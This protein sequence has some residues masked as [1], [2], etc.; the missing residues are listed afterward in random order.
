M[1]DPGG[2]GNPLQGLLGDLL[3]L[4]GGS[5]SGAA[6]WLE[7]A[8]TLA[9]GVA[10]DGQPEPNPDPLQRIHLEELAR[11][12]ELHVAEATGLA[13]GSGGS[14]PALVPV[15][16]G[17]WALATLDSWAPLMA[18]MIKAQSGSA[19][20][21]GPGAGGLPG[22]PDDPDG[23]EL[24]GLGELMSRF[25]T[26]MGP[27]LLG[28]QFGSAA[29]HLAQRALGRYALPLPWLGGGDLGLVPQNIAAFAEDW[30]LPL[31]QAQLWVCIH[32]LAAHAVLSQPEVA[33]HIG[34]L[35]DAAV[36]TA[37][38]ST[39]SLTERMG[40]Q[41]GD[42]DALQNLLSDPEALLSD[43]LSPTERYSSE[44]LVAVTTAVGAYVD[45]VT[46]RVAGSLLG[47]PGA[48]GEAW[49][50]Y[51]TADAAG[52]QAA[53]TLFGLDLGRAQVDRGAAFVRGVVER[54]GEA[55][56]ARLWESARNLPT[57]A[58]LDAPGLW[59]ERIDLPP[60]GDGLR[61]E[62]AGGGEPDGPAPDGEPPAG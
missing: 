22:D 18:R 32:E 62:G 8:R 16:R 2:S 33:A 39:Q 54:A 26:T 24:A 61:P 5:P 13:A 52:E 48:L 47:S 3:K 31:D 44:R 40:G 15:G 38:T 49:Y 29:G 36:G 28:M 46:S 41:L 11:V 59:L 51:R 53:G 50:R 7:A 30:S 17:A 27:V 6:P 34:E 19:P 58:E 56:L 45:H 55:G 57:P 25:A 21:F 10:T 20:L 1:N 60:L 37:M 12:A 4:I 9:Q 14:S 42:L 43:L 23:N 35:L